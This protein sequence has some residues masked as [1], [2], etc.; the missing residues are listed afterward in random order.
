MFLWIISSEPQNILLPNLVWWC[1]IISQSV[2]WK[3]GLLQSRSRLQQRV[4]C[5]CLSRWYLL[6]QQTFCYQTWHFDAS[7]WARVSC[8]EVGLLFL[9]S[10]SQQGSY[11]HDGFYCIFLN[12]DLFVFKLCFMVHC[13]KPVCLVMKLDC[14]LC[15]LRLFTP[16]NGN[17]KQNIFSSNCTLSSCISCI[18]YAL[19]NMRDPV[20]IFQSQY[21]S[22]KAG[23]RD[24]CFVSWR[25]GSVGGACALGGKMKK[26]S[27]QK[28]LH[29]YHESCQH[30]VTRKRCSLA[31]CIMVN[32]QFRSRAPN[33][34]YLP[35]FC[36]FLHLCHY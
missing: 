16:C 2:L 20:P 23:C 24:Q 3:I 21:G 12:A 4:Q 22:T 19:F 5:Q 31:D 13:H 1:S 14:C 11:D 27:C 34:D 35:V 15:G 30:L 33:L 29:F 25:Y 7:S 6:N 8:K 17:S 28:F 32:L 10:R 18:G 9:R 36:C 26:V